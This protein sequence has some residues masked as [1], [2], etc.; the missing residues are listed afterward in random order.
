MRTAVNFAATAFFLSSA[1]ICSAPV[2]AAGTGSAGTGTC[3]AA[4]YWTASPTTG[5]YGKTTGTDEVQHIQEMLNE[6]EAKTNVGAATNGP[7]NAS[8]ASGSSA[9]PALPANELPFAS[10]EG[11]LAESA[12]TTALATSTYHQPTGFLPGIK[13]SP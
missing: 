2:L 3:S 4:N 8:A 6:A 13:W 11:T 10:N 1:F 5:N 7:G 12:N 9:V